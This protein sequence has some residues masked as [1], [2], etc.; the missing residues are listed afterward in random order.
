MLALLVLVWRLLAA[1]ERGAACRSRSVL[2][3][4]GHDHSNA[5]E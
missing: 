4:D 2:D 5:S 3:R 1:S